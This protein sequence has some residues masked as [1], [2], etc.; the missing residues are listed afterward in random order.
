MLSFIL[1]VAFIACAN[2]QSCGFTRRA[3]PPSS[4]FIDECD[5]IRYYFTVPDQCLSSSCP[6][7]FDAHGFTM[8]AD[9]QNEGSHLRTIGYANGFIVVNPE[10]PT[11]IWIPRT[12]HPSIWRAYSEVA[13]V[14]NV[15]RNRTHF[16]GFSMGGLMTWD[17][18][19]KMSD[20]ICSIAPLAASGYDWWALLD[21]D[22][23]STGRGAIGLPNRI[24]DVLYGAGTLDK[25]ATWPNAEDRREDVLS[26]YNTTYSRGTVLSQNNAHLWTRWVLG[27]GNNEVAFEF[28]QHDYSAYRSTGHCFPGGDDGYAFSCKNDPNPAF[29]WGEAVIDFFINHPC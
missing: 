4:P 15:N 22:C 18:G 20:Q 3:A 26:L 21:G 19:C 24:P 17:A 5:G 25:L 14:Y 12:D 13:N 2:A 29:I 23:W 6:L 9:G 7:L 10:K 28:I 1:L 16:T 8:T 11:R 27:S